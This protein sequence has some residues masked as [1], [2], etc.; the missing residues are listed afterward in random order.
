MAHC[1]CLVIAQLMVEAQAMARKMPGQHWLLLP[2]LQTLLRAV[3]FTWLS[4]ACV[5]T[6]SCSSTVTH[7]SGD[8]EFVHG[9]WIKKIMKQHRNYFVL[10]KRHVFN[11]CHK[12]DACSPVLHH[13]RIHWR[14]HQEIST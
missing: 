12:T 11:Q 4:V 1:S 8:G 6:K 3:K 9:K 5:W 13:S 2:A 7:N 10:W 14:M